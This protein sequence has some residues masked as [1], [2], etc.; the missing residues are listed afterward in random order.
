MTQ[1]KLKAHFS[2][3]GSQPEAIKKLLAGYKKYSQQTLLGVTGSGKTFTVA[4]L[5]EKIQKPTLIL[6]H[7]KTL[8]AQL[9]QEFQSFF[10][11]NKVCYFVSYYD[12]YQPES[13]LPASD[14][15]I[16]KDAMINEQIERLRLEAATSLMSRTDTIVVASVSCIYGFGQPADFVGESLHLQ[17]GQN[18][19]RQDLLRALVGIQYERSDLELHPGRFRVRGGTVDVIQG[20]ANSN[21]VRLELFD[22]VLES[23]TDVHRLSGRKINDL[24]EVWLYPARPFIVP[25]ARV[26]PALAAIREELK[27]RLPQLEPLEA[28][29]LNQRTNYD[30]EM[31]EQLGYCKGIENYSRHFD[32]R[33]VGQPP[34]TLIDFFNYVTKDW[35]FVID[36]S[37][38]TIPQVRGMYEGDRARKKNLIDYGFRLESAYD[39]RPLKFAEFEKSLKHVVYTSATPSQYELNSSEQVVEQIVRPTGLVDP[40]ITIKPAV[41]QVADLVQ[42]IKKTTKLGYRCLVTT[43][44]KR[45]AEDLTLHFLNEGIR[46]QYLHSD[47][48]TLERIKIIRD[49]R[50]GK[51]DCLVGIN[52][53]REG[54]DLPE[55]ALVAILDADKEGFLRN[56]RSLI[57][58]TGRAARNIDGRVIMYADKITESIKEAIRETDR[59]RQVQLDYNKKYRITPK[60]IVKA[61]AQEEVVIEPG[62]KGRALELDKMLID[63]EGQMR[64]EAEAL[65]FEKAIE[66]RNK[67]ESLKA[68]L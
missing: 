7:N 33:Q 63:L 25:E 46:V 40:V 60:S 67:I 52:L 68:K 29:R 58:T 31:I 38:A 48:E 6:S 22:D 36:E 43:L 13:Y 66:L 11:E 35:L 10:P 50:L 42:E 56:S 21:I 54:L 59:R 20:S 34:F 62:E 9:F 41:G 18:I 17:V 27:Q 8:A 61:I 65:N 28:Y 57:Q 5:I 3:K 12:Y 16:E 39:N 53:L 45:M 24:K 2:P 23:I 32:Q 4:N 26:K 64:S 19:K 14:T 44:T 37:H 47:I 30:L 15:Y 51:F 55:V 1:F 49:L